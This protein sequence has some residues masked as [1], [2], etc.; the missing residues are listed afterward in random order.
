M[1]LTDPDE[2]YARNIGTLDNHM[3]TT[4]YLYWLIDWL[5]DYLL[6]SFMW[7]LLVED[8][9]YIKEI[10]GHVLRKY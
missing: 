8:G 3:V 7:N 9:Q 2:C 6:L 4:L 5:I 10:D 1:M